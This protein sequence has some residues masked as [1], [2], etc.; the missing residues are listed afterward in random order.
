MSRQLPPRRNL[1]YLNKQAKELLQE[2]RL[3]DPSAQLSDA[4]HAVAREYGFAS[5]RCSRRASTRPVG[6]CPSRVRWP[7][8]GGPM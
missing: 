8:S 5:C 1:E 3:H 4:Q 2:L 6:A 7:V